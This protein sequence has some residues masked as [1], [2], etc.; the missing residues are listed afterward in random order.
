[1]TS[2]LV[3][4]TLFC[5][6]AV[7]V[8]MA[9]YSGRVRVTQSREINAPIEQVF[10]KVVDFQQWG[11]WNPWLAH[12][13]GAELTVS[14]ASG[15]AGSECAW[16]SDKAGMGIIRLLR[17]VTLKSIEQRMQ[18]KQ[19]FMVSGLS[20]WTFSERDGVTEVSWH[21]KARVAFTMRA[22]SQTVKG[23]LELD[24]RYG[25]DR[26]ASLLE[27]ADAPRYQLSVLGT[28]EVPAC[29][30]VYHTYQGTI[31]GLPDAMRACFAELHSQLAAMGIAP[32]GAPLAFY[33]RTNIKF[34]TT[35]CLMGMPVGE[36]E[37]GD[38]PVRD[39]P[40]QRVF[41]VVLKG[42]HAALELAWYL[43]MQRLT[44]DN[45][46]SDQR[47]PPFETY[48][49]TGVTG[50]SNDCVTEVNVPLLTPIS[51]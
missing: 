40:A 3:F 7:L 2:T 23:A 42:D 9:R 14:G 28:Q 6:V 37:V 50:H 48:L 19:P 38:M 30:Y 47:L 4:V 5:V 41:R 22:F 25:L 49:V 33:T 43:A 20:H 46:K 21:I 51:L 10:A 17:S 11:G 26:L 13:P 36:A 45:L 12:E 31:K 29:R 1:M 34:R 24:S 39:M 27:P 15:Q 16:N 8:Y 18:L 32:I 35:V 44:I